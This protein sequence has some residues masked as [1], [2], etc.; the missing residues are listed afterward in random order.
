MKR[1]YRDRVDG[2][3]EF[4]RLIQRSLQPDFNVLD[5]GCGFGRTE[6]DLRA[7]ARLVVGCD[8]GEDVKENYF[9]GARTQGSGYNLPFSDSVFDVI[10]MDYV[11][12]HLEFPDKC[13]SELFRVLRPEG[14]LFVRTPNLFH[15]VSLISYVT[16]HSF[17]RKAVQWIGQ[18]PE[19]HPFE[20]YYRVNTCKAAR[21]CFESAGFSTKEIRMVEKEPTYLVFARSAFLLGYGYE[22]LVNKS[23]WFA[24]LRSNI[25]ACFAKP[26]ESQR[27]VEGGGS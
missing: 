22:R 5:L 3:T 14:K 8:L 20:T 27:E 17:H 9:V 7:K 12:E 26:G 16:P 15:Y 2:T 11:L 1:L 10:I 21:R 24:Q 4:Y 19:L 6:T 23:N 13:A 18:S 25:F